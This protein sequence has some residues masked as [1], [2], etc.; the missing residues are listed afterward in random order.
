MKKLIVI[1]IANCVLLTPLL[2]FSQMPGKPA[3]SPLNKTSTNPFAQPPGPKEPAGQKKM[4]QPPKPSKI[5]G[6]IGVPFTLPGIVGLGAGGWAGSD[7]LFNL[8]PDIGVYVE[9]VMPEDKKFDISQVE[10]TNNILA[11]FQKAG[12]SPSALRE[13]NEPPLP[14]FHVLIMVNSV[15]QEIVASCSCRLFEAVTLKRVALDPGITYQ[16]I[17]WEKQDLFSATP[18]DFKETLTKSVDDLTSNFV[19]RFHYFQNL[20]SQMQSH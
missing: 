12:I 10:V 9:I 15:E 3:Q 17:T 20:R 16:A 1:C 6:G 11:I 7:N 5:K 2:V 19:E 4:P 14:L 13:A 8:R 18:K